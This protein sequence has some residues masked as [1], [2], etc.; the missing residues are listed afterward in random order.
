[1][2]YSLLTTHYPLLTTHHSLLTTHYPLLTTH[3]SLP[4][5]HYPLLTTYYSLLTTHYSLLTTHYSLLTT[6]YSLLTTHYSLLT[7]HY[8]L[9]QA[10][11]DIP[12][13]LNVSF[14]AKT[15]NQSPNAVLGS[16][17][18]AEPPMALG[19]AAFFAARDAIRAVRADGGVAAPFAVEA[20]LTVER[21]QQACLVNSQQF[22]LG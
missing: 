7:T 21:I 10:V 3:Y 8:C 5:T 14:L 6:H 1:M 18:S 2:Y 16:K 12:L 17:A 22:T 13:E 9:P 11:A 20:P 15:P 19:S 4:T